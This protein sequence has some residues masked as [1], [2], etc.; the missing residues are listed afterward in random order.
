MILQGLRGAREA[1]M[2]RIPSQMRGLLPSPELELALAADV[3]RAAEG[4]RSYAIVACMPQRLFDEGDAVIEAAAACLRDLLRDDDISGLLGDDQCLVIGLPDT[5][6]DGARVLAYRLKSDL[7]LRT[8]RLGTTV[9][10][11]GYA[12]LPDDGT[13]AEALLRAARRAVAGSRG[14]FG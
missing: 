9:W 10:M 5:A 11:A 2:M 13:T 12:C 8:G 3:E 14:H 1:K 6:L 4:G 7:A